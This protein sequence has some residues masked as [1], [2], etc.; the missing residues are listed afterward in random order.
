MKHVTSLNQNNQEPVENI[1][2][3]RKKISILGA[4]GS[5]G[6]SSFDLLKHNSER[7]EV[8]TLV[9][10]RNAKLLAE[11]AID[12]KASCA[13][14]A[15]ETQYRDLKNMLSGTGIDVSAGEG[16]VIGAAGR[17]VDMT[18]SAIVGAAGLKPS[19]AAVMAGNNLALANKECLVSAGAV[20]MNA[21]KH[22]GVDLLP[23]DSEHNAIFQVFDQKEREAISRIILTASG[24]PFRDK[25]RD[26]LTHITP[27]QAIAHPNW[28]MGAKI[29][30]DSAT[31][32]NKGLEIIEAHYLFDMPANQIE[33]V[34]HPQSIIHS[35]VEYQDG[36]VLAQMGASDMRTP[37]AYAL[38]WPH[39]MKTTGRTLSFDEVLDL[40]IRPIDRMRFPFV[41]MAFD[42]INEGPARATIM[43]A[44]NE[45][46]VDAFLKGK[47]SFL[48]IEKL[49]ADV[50]S[51]IPQKTISDLE[52][53]LSIDHD[54]RQ[55]AQELI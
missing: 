21:V 39:R 40:Q 24:G 53:V 51:K 31:M 2:K 20:F 38:A 15:D 18:I 14:I 11:Q 17:P 54:A 49:V 45:I 28:S 52:N 23:V 25:T 44:A 3:A 41:Q 13:V 27:E 4:T 12:L 26:D 19:L 35:M 47:I 1:G 43:N 8:D 33:A 46:A 34:M 10:G 32:M 37:I 29:S 6:Q 36:S 7:F 9:G 22:A 48:A 16:A 30:V 5:I 42:A 55:Y 50:L